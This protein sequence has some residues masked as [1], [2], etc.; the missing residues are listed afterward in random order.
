[1]SVTRTIEIQRNL[2]LDEKTMVILRNFDIDWNCGT[3]FIQGLIRSGITG[4][5]V[6]KALTEALFDYKL[7]CQKG[8]GDYE[9]L[10]HV[11]EQLF[12]KLNAQGVSVPIE[13][14]SSLCQKSLV[15]DQ[16]REYLING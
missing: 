10:Y 8:V 12:T 4:Q 16:I 7:M 11:L 14:V 6:N 2:Q 1:M 13:T 5:P 9:R 3:R 15:P